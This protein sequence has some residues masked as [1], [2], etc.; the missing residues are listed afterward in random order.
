MNLDFLFIAGLLVPILAGLTGYLLQHRVIAEQS[1]RTGEKI[2]QAE[3]KLEAQPQK[4]KPAWDL[5]RVTLEQ[6]FNRNLAQISAIFWLSVVVMLAGFGII[7]WGIIWE[8]YRAFHPEINP[9]T[10]GPAGL[11]SLSGI[12]TEFIGASFLFI[13]RSTIHQAAT[14]SM[15]LE[16]INAVGM[17]MQILDT[18]PDEPKADDLKSKT[19]AALVELLIKQAYEASIKY[20]RE[21][22]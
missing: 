19:K 2:A 5:A 16:R 12:V 15:T 13:Y 17:A 11:A 10:L 3:S 20:Q 1:K 9:G 14:Y 22:D 18:I 21:K 7:A 6:Y 8:I 4:S